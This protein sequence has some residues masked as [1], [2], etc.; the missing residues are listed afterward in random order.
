MKNI[1]QWSMTSS[2]SFPNCSVSPNYF[3]KHW[4]RGYR[5]RIYERRLTFWRSWVQIPLPYL[6]F[7]VCFPASKLICHGLESRLGHF[8]VMSHERSFREM[9]IN[10]C[11]LYRWMPRWAA[12][13]QNWF[14]VSKH[15]GF[16]SFWPLMLF[17]SIGLSIQIFR[18]LLIWKQ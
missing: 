12:F 5:S 7:Q 17:V 9:H 18:S 8:T 4:C 2:C 3:V 14:S 10:N 1:E 16:F 11:F 15:S 13:G 6:F